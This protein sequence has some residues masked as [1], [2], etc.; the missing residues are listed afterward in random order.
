MNKFTLIN[1]FK[2]SLK[3][4]S[5]L[6]GVDYGA[7]K[8]GLSLSDRTKIIASPYKV[9]IRKNLAADIQNICH[10]ID[11]NYVGGIVFGYPIE[12]QGTIGEAC[13]MVENFS[14]KLAEEKT[15][16]YY[17]QDERLSTSAV[18]Q[19]LDAANISRIKKD[20]VDDKMAASYILQ[21]VLDIMNNKII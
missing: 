2:S 1:E 21:I 7:K 14:Q 16:P 10:I 11:E 8:I 15:L 17:F 6:L 9:L 19:I 20:L 5:R 13:K 12:T 3:E 18:R 4:N